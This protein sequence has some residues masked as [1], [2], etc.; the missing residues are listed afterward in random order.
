MELTSLNADDFVRILQEP[1]NALLKQY[2]A[3]F[4]SDG[5]ALEFTDSA[6]RAI[7]DVA[8]RANESSEDIGARRL[9]TVLARLLEDFLYDVPDAFE[10]GSIRVDEALVH[11]RLDH[12]LLD[13]DVRQ[14]IL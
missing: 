11:E 3:L 13:D 10:G 6:V 14:Y 1:E 7:A 2:Q 5:V 9:Q 8:S 12:V 4:A